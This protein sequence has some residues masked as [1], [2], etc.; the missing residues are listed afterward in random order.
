MTCVFAPLQHQTLAAVGCETY[1]WLECFSGTPAPMICWPCVHCGA[2]THY[3]KIVFFVPNLCMNPEEDHTHYPPQHPLEDSTH[4][5]LY[6]TL[7][8]PVTVDRPWHSQAANDHN[9]PVMPS[10][11]QSAINFPATCMKCVVPI[12]VPGSA[13]TRTVPFSKPTPWTP[14]QSFILERE[15]SDHPDQAFVKQLIND[16]CHGCFISY[17]GPQFSYYANNLV[18]AY[19]HPTNYQC[20]STK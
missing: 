9:R 20:H 5:L 1:L 15:L 7:D 13:L 10:T 17:K 2:R 3:P 19:Q 6:P 12:T 8:N 14:L 11:I 16:P 4:H 18:S